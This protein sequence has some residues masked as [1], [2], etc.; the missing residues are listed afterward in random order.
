MLGLFQRG[1]NIDI[2]QQD[3]GEDSLPGVTFAITIERHDGTSVVNIVNAAAMTKITAGRWHYRHTVAAGAAL[4]LYNVRFARTEGTTTAIVDNDEFVVWLGSQPAQGAGLS[5][6]T[7]TVKDN[8]T[9]AVISGATVQ[10]WERDAAGNPTRKLA[11]AT[12][13]SNGTFTIH[14]DPGTYLMIVDAQGYNRLTTTKT[15]T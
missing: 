10:M 11:E 1:D 2:F 4:G 12:T 15:I 7:D 9:G 5:T 14:I 8:V 6:F 3:L 13:A